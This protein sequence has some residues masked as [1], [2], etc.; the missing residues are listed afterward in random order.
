MKTLNELFYDVIFLNELS[1]NI[2]AAL[3]FSDPDGPS[4]RSGGSFGVCQHDSRHGKY[5][6]TCLREC[7]F[8][9]A[10]IVQVQ[11]MMGDVKTLAAKLNREIVEKYDTLQLS[12]CLNSAMNVTTSKGLIVT[13]TAAILALADYANQYGSI[14]P[15]FTMY[16]DD[17]DF[18][19]VTIQEVQEWKL[20]H[21][22]YG[23][24]HPK[25]CD[26]RYLN[27]LEVCKKE[28]V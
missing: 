24:E 8:T 14:G 12:D 17:N 16:L 4:G 9:E 15:T 1:G 26:R 20:K 6:K 21:T 13:D 5:A 2:R 11:D 25:D 19:G 22:K 28:G 18:D 3:C 7:G 23:R 10:E 27:I